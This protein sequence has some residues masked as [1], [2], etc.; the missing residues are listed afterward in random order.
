MP[1]TTI[2]YDPTYAPTG[3]DGL[4]RGPDRFSAKEIEDTFGDWGKCTESLSKAA[5]A[6]AMECMQDLL[7]KYRGDI[8]DITINSLAGKYSALFWAQN[9]HWMSKH[10]DMPSAKNRYECSFIEECRSR[11]F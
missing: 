3:R 4:P 10:I 8:P 5:K 7:P 2:E 9:Q 1:D 11:S 6:K